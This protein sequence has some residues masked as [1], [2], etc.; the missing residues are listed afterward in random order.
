MADCTLNISK[1]IAST[2]ANAKV[3]GMEQ[4][5]WAIPRAWLNITW[6]STTPNLITDLTKINT[7]VAYPITSTG[8]AK[9]F[10]AGSDLVAADDRPDAWKHSFTLQQFEL[11]AADINNVDAMHDIVF[12]Y[13]GKDKSTDGDGVFF[14]VGAKSGLFKEAD[15]KRTNTNH[16]SR[17]LTLSNK[18]DDV[19]TS[20]LYVIK[21]TGGYAATLAMIVALETVNP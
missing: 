4:K 1:I 9:L 21:K 18:G 14:A 13:E 8:I 15:T 6:D 19:E 17:S 16:G 5:C 7:K 12:I 2:C 20:S 10:D 3:G 11:T